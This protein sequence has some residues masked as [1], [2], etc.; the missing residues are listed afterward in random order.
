[1]DKLQPGTA[2]GVE[3]NIEKIALLFPE[4]LTEIED[5]KVVRSY[6]PFVY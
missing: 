6:D 5:S 2:D 4:A 3:E 1:M